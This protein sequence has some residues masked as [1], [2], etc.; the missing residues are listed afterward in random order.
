LIS[1]LSCGHHRSSNYRQ[2]IEVLTRAIEINPLEISYL[3]SRGVDELKLRNFVR[4][5]S[6]FT[7]F[8]EALYFMRAE[9]FL[10]QQRRGEAAADLAYVDDDFRF[11]T[12]DQLRTKADLLAE[13]G[14]FGEQLIQTLASSKWRPRTRR[15]DLGKP[16]TDRT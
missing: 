1:L 4:A 6:D 12:Y 15:G 2:A 13:W 5:E 3:F 11:W 10:G 7:H 16:G 8:L 14:P 9:A